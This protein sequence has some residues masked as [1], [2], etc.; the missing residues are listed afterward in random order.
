MDVVPRSLYAVFRESTIRH[1]RTTASRSRSLTTR[2]LRKTGLEIDDVYD[3]GQGP[4]LASD[5]LG[6]AGELSHAVISIR[7]AGLTLW[8]RDVHAASPSQQVASAGMDYL[9]F[10]YLLSPLHPLAPTRAKL[11]RESALY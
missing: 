6:T 7:N 3:A 5:I 11:Q 9:Q 8:W 1:G 10:I 2:R 4:D